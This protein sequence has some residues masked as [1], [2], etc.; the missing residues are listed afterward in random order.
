MVFPGMPFTRRC[1]EPGFAK[2][3]HYIPF[4]HY[5][6]SFVKNFV[7]NHT[8]PAIPPPGRAVVGVLSEIRAENTGKA[9]AGTRYAPYDNSLANGSLSYR[10]SLQYTGKKEGEYGIRRERR[11]RLVWNR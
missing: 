10:E 1:F 6:H 5:I 8:K 11:I 4:I 7:K 3:L 2:T 9:L